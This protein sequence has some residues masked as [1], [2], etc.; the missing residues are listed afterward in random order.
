[1]CRRGKSKISA[2]FWEKEAKTFC[3]LAIM[4]AAIPWL[5]SKKFFGSFLQKR[6]ASFL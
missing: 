1:M 5:N 2:S 6:T 3:Y 4:V